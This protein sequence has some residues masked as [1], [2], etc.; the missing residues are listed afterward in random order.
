MI[1]ECEMDQQKQQQHFA[2]CTATTCLCHQYQHQQQLH[3]PQS[4]L[5]EIKQ[6][7]K[8]GGGGIQFGS[9]PASKKG[10]SRV[11]LPF[12]QELFYEEIRLR[13]ECAY[14]IQRMCDVITE[15]TLVN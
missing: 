11:G 14:Q 3:P 4:L 6:Y 7:T 12:R 8:T 13:R 5:V 9:K 10:V 15:E 2:L 1:R